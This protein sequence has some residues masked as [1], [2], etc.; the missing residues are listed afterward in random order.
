[1]SPGRTQRGRRAMQAGPLPDVMILLAH[2]ITN[3]VSE[4]LS[5]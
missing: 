5:P 2:C 4:R 1:M 3:A